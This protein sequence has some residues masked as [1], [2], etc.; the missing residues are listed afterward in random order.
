MVLRRT[1]SSVREARARNG[2]AVHD[3]KVKIQI[4]K[5]YMEIRTSKSKGEE[6]MYEKWPQVQ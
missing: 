1:T 2:A 6:K 4:R 3:C 5:V